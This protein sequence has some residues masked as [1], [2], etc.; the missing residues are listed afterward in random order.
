MLK[1]T[2]LAGIAMLALAGAVGGSNLMAQTPAPAVAP[3]AVLS[4][5]GYLPRGGAPSSLALVPPPPEPGS[6][7]Q[8]RDDAMS[9]IALGQ[10]GG[11]RWDLA[12]QDADL[13][14]PNAA[15]TFSCAMGVRISEADTPHL[16]ALLRR[17]L[18]DTG[19]STYPTKTKFQR[20][21][22]FTVNG[23]PICTPAIDAGLRRDGSY[24]SGH[25]AV[26]WGWAL[27]LAEVDPER[28]EAIL[29]RG[30]A[31]GHS[32]VVCN[33]HWLSD[34]DEGRVMGAATVARLHGSSEFRADVEAA[35]SE[36]AAARARGLAPNRDCAREAA[37]LAG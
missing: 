33:V 5:A 11:P 34:T 22:P 26:G 20:A 24:P 14:F 29:A 12:T 13:S 18:A 31:F 16:Y 1:K 19:L 36:V 32:R 37:Q 27:I 15:G 30:R 35:R 4:T 9:K 28:A 3:P 7:A 10:H 8:A 25:V 17:T 21:R 2:M 6:P 23:A